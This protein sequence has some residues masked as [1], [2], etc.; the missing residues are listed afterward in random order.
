MTQTRFTSKADARADR[1]AAADGGRSVHL[2]TFGCQMNKYDS[3]LVEGR[4]RAR[5]WRVAERLDEADVVLFNTCSVREHAEERVYSW[6]GELK[7]HKRRRPDLV[8]GVMGCL[9]QRAQEEV[10]RRAGHVD[11]VVGTRRLQH[12]P[13]LVDEIYER[14]ADPAGGRSDAERVLD[15]EM[16]D[17]VAVPRAGE[18]YTGGLAGFLTVMRGCDLNCTYCIVPRTR[19]RV[20]SRPIP[21]LVD[22]AR[23][24]VD[25][26]ARVITLLGQ[27]VDS[28]G[29]DLPAPGPGEPR[30]TGRAGR[31]GLADLLRELQQ[32]RDLARIRLVTLH[33]AYANRALA[34]AIRDCDKVDR[35][36]PLPAQS[37]SDAVL[38]AM[39]RGY[40]TDLYRKRVDLLREVVPDLELGSDWIVGFPGESESDFVASEAFLDEVGFVQN[41]VFQY[42]P[43]PE[44]RA[45]ELD[46]DVPRET[47][48]E[49]NHRLLAAAHRAQFGRLQE[50]VG[51]EVEVFVEAASEKRPGWLT[52]RSRHG[53]PVTFEG[54][55]NA[56]G[57]EVRVRVSDSSPFGLAGVAEHSLCAT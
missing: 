33:P 6:L 21:A 48:R 47:K 51:R 54:E 16:D 17:A 49:R 46:D 12:I 4:F 36:L 7:A 53:L 22:E 43:R 25:Q 35:F 14:R 30:G 44:T 31:P 52:G 9:A 42:D 5:G 50:Y 2:V 39:R 56:I 37:G 19:G 26:G 10:F 34:E 1:A 28:Y 15:V 32:V 41:Y 27:T 24:M 3:L 13:T 11:L 40:T 18:V 45:H 20:Q 55:T 57:T 23:W 29:E 38:R 8:L